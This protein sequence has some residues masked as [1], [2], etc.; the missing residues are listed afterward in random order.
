MHTS[1]LS[2]MPWKKKK[3]HGIAS[4]FLDHIIIILFL[5]NIFIFSNIINEIKLEPEP[6]KQK[7]CTAEG[8]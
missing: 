8:V 5:N 1:R 6:G 2:Q 4:Y 3:K 7:Q